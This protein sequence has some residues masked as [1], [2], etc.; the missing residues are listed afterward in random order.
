[1]VGRSGNPLLFSHGLYHW[2]EWTRR[3][4]DYRIQRNHWLRLSWILPARDAAP[5]FTFPSV[6]AVWIHHNLFD[7]SLDSS[8]MDDIG[9]RRRRRPLPI[10]R[11]NFVR[12][13][14]RAAAE[15]QK[16][17]PNRTNRSP[18]PTLELTC[19]SR[20]ACFRWTMASMDDAFAAPAGR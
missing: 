7:T 15:T 13:H 9:P 10:Y 12:V 6:K 16:M 5:S 20:V 11:L 14:F 4:G 17:R 18:N 3:E 8:R 1:M 19:R 2:G